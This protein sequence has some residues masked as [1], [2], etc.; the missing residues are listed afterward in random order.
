MKD[1][2]ENDRLKCN[3]KLVKLLNKLVNEN[4]ELRFGQ[5]LD[6]WNFV[7]R[8]S[9]DGEDIYIRYWEDEFSTESAAILKRVE[10]KLR[11]KYD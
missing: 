2:K 11:S 3:K 7:Q 6:N 10:I 8:E 4:P 1:Y 5:I 9:F